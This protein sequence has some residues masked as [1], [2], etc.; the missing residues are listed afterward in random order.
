MKLKIPTR[1]LSRLVITSD[2]HFGARDK[3]HK[4]TDSF[5]TAEERDAWCIAQWNSVCTKDSL[6]IHAGDLA[7][8]YTGR[9]L[10][11]LNFGRLILVQ[12]NHDERHLNKATRERLW[13]I[14]E[15][16]DLTLIFGKN[17]THPMTVCHY[18]MWS[19]N[20]SVHGAWLVH[21]H[22]HG[23][24]QMPKQN[25]LDVCT[26]VHGRPL[27]FKEVLVRVASN[28]QYDRWHETTQQPQGRPHGKEEEGGQEEA[29]RHA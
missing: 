4:L 17:D 25:T 3:H 29:C 26:Y 11:R 24:S 9:Y 8:K 2:Q 27:S 5:E 21:G 19:W 1:D 14:C 13:K 20:K 6:V 15:I 22:S 12:G 18:P 28:E 23:K 16:L 10:D 7:F